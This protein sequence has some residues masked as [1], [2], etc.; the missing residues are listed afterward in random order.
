MDIRQN[1]QYLKGVGPKKAQALKKIGIET[2]YDLSTYYP[3]RYEDLSSLQTIGSLKAGE[4]ANIQGKI[5]A[6]ADRNTRRG[7]KLLTVMIYGLSSVRGI[8]QKCLTE[9]EVLGSPASCF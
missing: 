6:I 1:V 7:L 2:I 4:T 8:R 9:S 5:V 3:R